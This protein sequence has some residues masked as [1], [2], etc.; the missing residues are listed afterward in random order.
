M[1]FSH[2]NAVP[3]EDV[4]MQSQPVTSCRS[5]LTGADV[6]GADFTNALLD[7]S[8]QIVRGRLFARVHAIWGHGGY[9]CRAALEAVQIII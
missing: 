5:D 2:Q 3:A 1:F 7:K 6:F 4:L 8:Q 9:A